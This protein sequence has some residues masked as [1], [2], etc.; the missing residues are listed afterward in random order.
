MA[1]R[2]R[3]VAGN[4]KL[5][6]TRSFARELVGELVAGVAA[7][8]PEEGVTIVVCPT[9]VHIPDVAEALVGSSL[10]LGAQNAADQ[11][12][13]AFTGEVSAS[14]LAE[15][16]VSHVIVGH[17][18]RRSHYGDTDDS[19]AARAEAVLAAG[20]VPIVCV[21]ETLAE[22]DADRVDEVIGRQLDA[23][24]ARVGPSGIAGSVIAY[25]PVWAI[26]TG[27]TATPEQAQAVH[28]AIRDRI[29]AL[30]AEVATALPILY[31]GSMKPDNA[32]ELI[33]MP[34]IDGGLIGGASLAAGDFLAIARAAV[35]A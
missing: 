16:G 13:G 3:I 4:W 15:F 24:T 26:G 7:D 14:M 35:R 22:R 1:E 19:V 20:L 33:G 29:A 6:G 30:H 5:N 10:R 28:S 2:Q 27:R 11:P 34:D 12:G 17:S 31:G 8:G 23:L 18:E 32:A 25:E 21:G 9:A